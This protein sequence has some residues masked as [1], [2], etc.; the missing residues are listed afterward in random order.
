MHLLVERV[1]N[2][3]QEISA[4][5]LKFP[6]NCKEIEFVL[7]HGK[8]LKRSSKERRKM[9]TIFKDPDNE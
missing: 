2:S 5:L 3:F 9:S 1:S 7:Y 6:E 4:E 8:S